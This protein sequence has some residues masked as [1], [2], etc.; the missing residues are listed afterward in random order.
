VIVQYLAPFIFA[1]A[2]EDGDIQLCLMELWGMLRDLCAR[3]FVRAELGHL[4]R[5]VVETLC[6]AELL[7]PATELAIVVH[8][9]VHM[10]A[11]ILEL[12]PPA[13]TWMYPIE[14]CV[15]LQCQR[16]LN[17]LSP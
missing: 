3:R 5:R 15:R 16:L 8:L 6:R 11:D 1:G 7:L 13:A 2:F 10:V 9:P 4:Q 17:S 12:G 14:R